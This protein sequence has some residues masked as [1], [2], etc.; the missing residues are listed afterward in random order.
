MVVPELN[1]ILVRGAPPSRRTLRSQPSPG[2]GD[3]FNTKTPRAGRIQFCTSKSGTIRH[4]R[5]PPMPTRLSMTDRRERGL[6][7][8]FQPN[9]ANPHPIFPMAAISQIPDFEPLLPLPHGAMGNGKTAPSVLPG[10]GKVLL[11]VYDL[12]AA[13]WHQ[14]SCGRELSAWGWGLARRTPPANQPAAANAAPPPA[15]WYHL[16]F[17]GIFHFQDVPRAHSHP[18]V[19]TLYDAV[20]QPG[21]KNVL[22]PRKSDRPAGFL[23][24]FG[25]S[26][27]R[28]RKAFWKEKKKAA[29]ESG[30][31]SMKG[32]GLRRK[33]SN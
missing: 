6:L 22:P 18:K 1:L 5:R 31:D 24:L 2:C 17:S 32:G 3:R 14:P 9:A 10:V 29:T 8:A 7:Q 15:P 20:H 25:L 26:I 13:A 27:C 21:L 23:I 16:V 28:G 12:H 4:L 30:Q 33:I 11:S 19:P